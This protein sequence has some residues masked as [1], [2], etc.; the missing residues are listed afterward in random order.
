MI[1]VANKE[2]EMLGYTAHT[3][4]RGDACKIIIG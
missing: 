3:E 1:R 2:D 4:K